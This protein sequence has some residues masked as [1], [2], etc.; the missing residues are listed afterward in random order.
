MKQRVNI[1][2][3]I[4]DSKDSRSRGSTKSVNKSANQKTPINLNSSKNS[5]QIGNDSAIYISQ[6]EDAIEGFGG[7]SGSQT[8]VQNLTAPGQQIHSKI[9]K[10][11]PKA[12]KVEGDKSNLYTNWVQQQ[13]HNP[14]QSLISS[15]KNNSSQQQQ[16]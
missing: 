2:T 10:K 7:S 16:V 6:N 15:A 5:Q 8:N 12:R 4:Q 11:N 1:S 13:D 9:T 14:P 3:Y